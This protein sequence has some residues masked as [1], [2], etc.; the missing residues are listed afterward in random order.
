LRK[1]DLILTSAARIGLAQ[2]GRMA[3]ANGS[4]MLEGLA[5]VLRDHMNGTAAGFA[6]LRGEI[7]VVA[8]LVRD[9]AQ[10]VAL[11]GENLA[12]HQ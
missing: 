11:Q 5:Q 1:A 8:P 9:L 3:K 12:R 7:G 6:D 2:V 4:V 10:I